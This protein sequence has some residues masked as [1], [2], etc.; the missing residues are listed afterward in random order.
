MGD[1]AVWGLVSGLIHFA[2]I[3][4]LYG[5]PVVD[6][7]YVLAADAS[8]A[9]RGWPSKSRYLIT[10][11][12]GTQIEVYV[13]AIGFAWLYQHLPA[14]GLAAALLLGTLFAGLRVYPRFWNMW[15]QSTYPRRLLVT[16]A[17]NGIIGTYVIVIALYLLLP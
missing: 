12:L 11:F 1:I 5:N 13:I 4:I 9:V 14:D 10:Q 17:V 15:I 7:M 2:A 6:R 8:P 3:G 16:E